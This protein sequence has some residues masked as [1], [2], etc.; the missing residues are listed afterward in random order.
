MR[1]DVAV[2]VAF[3]RQVVAQLN[4]EPCCIIG[5]SFGGWVA[6]A[7]SLKYPNSVSSLVLAAPAGIRDDTFCGQYDALRPLLWETPAVDW[8][9]QLAKAFASLAGKSDK[10]ANFGL[11]QGVNVSTSSKVIFN[12]P[13]AAGRRS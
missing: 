1:Y 2:E 8:A 6:S 7:Y 11:A 9:L 5:H 4:I 10:A 13:D 12:E 3:V